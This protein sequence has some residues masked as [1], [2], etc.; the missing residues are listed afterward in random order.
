M[1][2]VTTDLILQISNAATAISTAAAGAAVARDNIAAAIRAKGGVAPAGTALMQLPAAVAGIP[3]D[4]T[5]ESESDFRDPWVR[6]ADRPAVPEFSGTCSAIFLVFATAAGTLVPKSTL[7]SMSA[8]AVVVKNLTTGASS[9]A[10]ANAIDCVAGYNWI[11]VL[12]TAMEWRVIPFNYTG[13]ENWQVL[14]LYATHTSTS[15]QLTTMARWLSVSANNIRTQSNY[16][17][18]LEHVFISSPKIGYAYYFL[19]LKRLASVEFEYTGQQGTPVSYSTGCCSYCRDLRNVKISDIGGSGG[20]LHDLSNAFS[21]N[22]LGSVI[23]DGIN[24]S[25]MTGFLKYSKIGSISGSITINVP[26]TMT[27]FSG[28]V[29]D[30]QGYALNVTSLT[31]GRATFGLFAMEITDAVQLAQAFVGNATLSTKEIQLGFTRG[32]YVQ[33][34]ADLLDAGWTVTLL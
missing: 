15:F 1:N 7:I 29:F 2:N 24:V 16:N 30:I 19:G 26:G 11:E 8:N 9:T 31:A 27:L 6:P 33:P 25:G 13:D 18:T 20:G 14:E 17:N 5:T 22:N 21:Q 4:T 12:D 23:L 34:L 28:S 3:Q 32:D 10:Q